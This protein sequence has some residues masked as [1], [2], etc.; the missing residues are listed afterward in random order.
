MNKENNSPQGRHKMLGFYGL[1]QE[2]D[3]VIFQRMTKFT[4]LEKSM[5]PQE[6]NRKYVDEESQRTDVTGYAPAINYA[7]DKHKNNPVHD[8]IIMI[9]NREMIGED[10]IR[11][12]LWV[13]T[14]TGEA[15]KRNY[16]V[17]PNSEG[18]DS[19]VYTHSGTLKATGKLE[20][21]TATSEDGWQT[22]TFTPDPEA[23]PTALNAASAAKVSTAKTTS[24]AE[25]AN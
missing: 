15:T 7:F 16:S 11:Q 1:P 5:N 9:T 13:D 21:G 22:A 17:I 18:G 3:E 14:E 19:N 6:Y 8:D 4:Q 12:T 24:K 23:K 2:N 20:H 25:A 10:A